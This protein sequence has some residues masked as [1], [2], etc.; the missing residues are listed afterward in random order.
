MAEQHNHTKHSKGLSLAFWL[1]AGF[2]VVE[3]IGG[4]YTNS[5]AIITDAIHD[6]GD[7]LAIGA[8]IVF[9]KISRKKRSP[10]FSY[11]Y[12]RWS[13]LSALLLSVMLLA[14]AGIMLWKSVN[15]FMQPHEVNSIG[16]L[17]LAVAGIAV[18][19]LAFLRIRN[20]GEGHHHHHGHSHDHSHS[21]NSKAIMLHLLEDVLGWIAVLVGAIII[22]YTQ[23]Y[24]IDPLL[25]VAIAL[26]VIYNAIKNL[27]GVMRVMLQAVPM[28]M[29]VDHVSK[30]LADIEGVTSVHDV[31]LW[32]V[33]GSYTVGTF[34]LVLTPAA[35]QNTNQLM[36]AAAVVFKK[37]KIDHPTVQWENEQYNC[38][39]AQC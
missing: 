8:G 4:I 33:D 7:A 31:H 15:A 35:S 24:W 13:L 17:W 38:P 36:E 3:L 34:H 10:Q 21:H 28:E 20:S 12:R 16:M 25:S 22:Y 1:N 5:T 30:E 9:E 27:S 23:W 2:S 18:N 32:S 29:N 37:Y 14:G 6:F 39:F 19:G 26:F 11:G